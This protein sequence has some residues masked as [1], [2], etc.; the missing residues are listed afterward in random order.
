MRS[1]IYERR[2]IALAT[3]DS[4]RVT[5]NFRCG[6]DR[7]TNNEL[8]RVAA[9]DDTGIHLE[10]GRVIKVAEALHLD[11]GIAV[12]SHASQGKTVDQVTV[13][14]PVSAFSQVNQA[15]FYVSMSRA[16]RAMHLYTDSKDALKEAIL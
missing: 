5:K 12:T 14:V 1:S 3:D 16:R 13:S 7:F 9:I 10:D 15:Q 11:Q 6:A 4:A 2:E 8:C